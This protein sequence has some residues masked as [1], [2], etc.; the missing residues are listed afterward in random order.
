VF[1]RAGNLEPQARGEIFLV[2]QH[3]IHI[4]GNPPIDLP[5]ALKSAA[6]LPE[7]GPVV[8]VIGNNDSVPP[9]GLHS[10]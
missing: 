3:H 5:R 9:G 4:P 2:A 8:Q 1:V 10:L 7:R 6:A